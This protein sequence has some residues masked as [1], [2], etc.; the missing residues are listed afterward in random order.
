MQ[1]NKKRRFYRVGIQYHNQAR[2][3]QE[4]HYMRFINCSFFENSIA[5]LSPSVIGIL[6]QRVDFQEI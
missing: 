1:A 2:E 4:L 6:S 3:Y 5:A